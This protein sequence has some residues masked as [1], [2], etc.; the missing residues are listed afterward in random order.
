MKQ[1]VERGVRSLKQRFGI[2]IDE[3]DEEEEDTVS[4]PKTKEDYLKLGEKKENK[5][6]STLRK[7]YSGCSHI[8]S[9]GVALHEE[10][11]KLK[12]G[13]HYTKLDKDNYIFD[14][15]EDISH[16]KKSQNKKPALWRVVGKLL[17]I[18]A[19]KATEMMETS[20]ETTSFSTKERQFYELIIKLFEDYE[21]EVKE[22]GE[23]KEKYN[24][25]EGGGRKK[26]KKKTKRRKKRSRTKK[27]K[28]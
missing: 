21:K 8:I 22:Y 3:S 2:K 7:Y 25:I 27:K 23:L 4:E 9:E 5:I 1:K 13:F 15:I 6:K 17:E 24:S 26:K 10:F 14:C 11:V 19:K 16:Y 12:G 20:D 28:K 18:D